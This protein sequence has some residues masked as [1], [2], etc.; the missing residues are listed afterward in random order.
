M[1][2]TI[3]MQVMRYINLFD[4]VTRVPTKHCFVY[5]NTLIFVVPKKLV[6]RAVGPD[7]KN[8]KKIS[9]TFRKKV[10][11]IAMPEKQEEISKFVSE[12][13]D[14]VSFNKLDLNKEVATLSAGRQNK[15]ALIGR[16]RA[17]EK[18]LESILKN[19]FDIKKF[20]IV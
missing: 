10:K 19:L 17:R 6:S 8:V 15:A 18:E 13:V 1:T 16:N 7:G 2:N 11:V 3:D 14:P 20:K 9:E 5:N 12:L 4:R